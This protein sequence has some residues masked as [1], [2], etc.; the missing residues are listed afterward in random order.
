MSEP[1][2]LVTGGLTSDGLF[3]GFFF[4]GFGAFGCAGRDLVNA[5]FRAFFY[6]VTGFLRYV[7]CA[8]GGL[9]GAVGD[10]SAGFLSALRDAFACTFGGFFGFVPGIFDVLSGCLGGE[11]EGEEERGEEEFHGEFSLPGFRRRNEIRFVRQ[12]NDIQILYILADY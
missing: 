2:T 8:V 3:F 4:D 11:A 1:V 7:D 5:L 10:A 6:R 9:L 12:S